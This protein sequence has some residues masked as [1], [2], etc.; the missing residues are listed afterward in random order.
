MT[1]Q[2]EA[3]SSTFH[4]QPV[5]GLPQSLIECSAGNV[6]ILT[7]MSA[8]GLNRAEK[9]RLVAFFLNTRSIDLPSEVSE[10]DGKILA[11]FADPNQRF[12]NFW[13][14]VSQLTD[15]KIQKKKKSVVLAPDFAIL[16][17]F[18][19]NF[20]EHLPGH[21]D[22][23]DCIPNAV[24][25]A[26]QIRK[27]LKCEI[28]NPPIGLLSIWATISGELSRW[29]EHDEVRR[30]DLAEAVFAVSS[31]AG[32][33]YLMMKAIEKCQGLSEYFEPMGLQ[34]SQPNSPPQ[35]SAKE[36]GTA[37]TLIEPVVET[38]QAETWKIKWE[39]LTLQISE[40]ALDLR[41]SPRRDGID[42]LASALEELR[43][44]AP[45]VEMGVEIVNQK[46]QQLMLFAKRAL[47]DHT[48]FE[49]F[50]MDALTTIEKTWTSY[51]GQD[52]SEEVT[53]SQI[54]IVEKAL[55]ETAIALHQCHEKFTRMR[56]LEEAIQSSSEEIRLAPTPSAKK[57]LLQERN[58]KNNEL[59]EARS[60][61][62]LA[63]EELMISLCPERNNLCLDAQTQTS[64]VESATGSFD[65]NEV[66]ISAKTADK[67]PNDVP[68]DKDPEQVVFDTAE[69]TSSLAG[70]LI[71]PIADISAAVVTDIPTDQITTTKLS[72]DAEKPGAPSVPVSDYSEQ[73]GV[74]CQPIWTAL[75]TNRPG[76]AYW[77]AIGIQDSSEPVPVIPPSLL[78]SVALA[79]HLVLPDS[80][81]AQ[82]LEA[83]YTEFESSWFSSAG[84]TPG[85]WTQAL[86]LLLLSA[87]L[88]PILLCPNSGASAVA[89][90]LHLNNSSLH[91]IRQSCEH[92]SERAQ[93]FRI[94]ASSF[95]TPRDR[96][97]WL[98]QVDV[99][100]TEATAWLER[101]PSMKMLYQA[102]SQVW[103]IWLKP[104]GLIKRLVLAVANGDSSSLKTV[105]EAI[106]A[107]S[108]SNNLDRLIRETD[109]RAIG[110]RGEEI[111]TR[112]L[113]QL[114]TKVSEALSLARRWVA[115]ED[116]RPKSSDVLHQLIDELSSSVLP[117][118]ESA[119]K[120]LQPVYSE[121]SFGLVATANQAVAKSL[122]SIRELLDP[123]VELDMVEAKPDVVLGRDLA[124]VPELD[125]DSQWNP[126]SSPADI[127]Q[128]LQSAIT[129]N[130]DKE[131]AFRCR[132]EA[133]DLLNAERIL[134][135]ID[136]VDEQDRVE[137][138]RLVLQEE[139]RSH[140]EMLKRQLDQAR[141]EIETGLAH[142]LIAEAERAVHEGALVEIAAQLDVIR[143]F[144]PYLL[145]LQGL[146]DAM[147]AK[148]T[149]KIQEANSR[150]ERAKGLSLS[151]SAMEDI[152]AVINAGDMLTANEYL[153]RLENGE[154]IHAA[155][156]EDGDI[157]SAYFPTVSEATD[158]ALDTA[159]SID[160]LNAIEKGLQFGPLD[161]SLLSESRRVGSSGSVSAWYLIKQTH[162]AAR[163]R[164][165]VVLS[166]LGF[167]VADLIV[168]HQVGGRQ[169]YA[170]K[171]ETIEDRSVC[172]I[173]Y[174]GS[175]AKGSYRVICVWQRPAEEDVVKLIGDTSMSSATILLY[176]G[177]LN[178]R[179]RSES[180][181]LARAQ[182]RSFLLVDETLL[183]FLASRSSAPA[184][185]LFAATLPFSHSQPYEPTS[186][187]VPT[188]MFFGRLQEL[189]AVQDQSG[190]CFIYGGRQL[191]KTALLR[192]A[193][194]DFHSPAKDRFAR[195]ID[196]RAEGIG[197]HR[198]SSEIWIILWKVLRQMG[199]LPSDVLEPSPNIKGRVDRFLEVMKTAIESAP[200]RRFLLLLDEADS[201]FESDGRKDF[202]ET[203][204]LKE[205]MFS[206]HW[207][208]KVVFAG[209]HNVLR[210]TEQANHPLAHLGEPIKVGPLLAAEEWRDAEDLIRGPFAAAGF[211]FSGR[212][213]IT[214]VLAQTNYYPS[215][216]QLY[217]H[218][219]LRHML[220]A[221]RA[222]VRMPGPR[223][224]IRETDVDAV[225]RRPS[226]REEI[227]SKFQ[228]T[229]Q[230]D[231]RYEVIAYSLAYEALSG[232]ASVA[233]GIA[234]W[235]IS[236]KAR[237][238][239]P[240]GFEVTSDVAFRVLLEEM[241]A[242]GVL[243]R[244]E[245]GNYA[246][247][248]PN[249]LLLLG[250][251][252]DVADVLVRERELPVE[253]E[254]DSFRARKPGEDLSNP[255]RHPL[256]FRQR[257][258]LV[259]PGSGVSIVCGSAALGLDQLIEFLRAD[260][261]CD[262]VEVLD[263]SECRKGFQQYYEKISGNRQPGSTLLII[264]PQSGWEVEWVALCQRQTARL[265]SKDR[266]LHV[267][268]VADPAQSWKVSR[269]PPLRDALVRLELQQW[270]DGFA[271][272]WLIDLGLA[273]ERPDRVLV[274]AAIGY[275]PMLLQ[276]LAQ[277]K[278][279]SLKTKLDSLNDKLASFE[280]L[281]ARKSDFG[282]DVVEPI[283]LLVEI[284]K[285]GSAET[286][287]DL[288]VLLSRDALFVNDVLSW[289][290]LLR[291]ASC[292]SER[293]WHV[294]DFAGRVLRRLF[295]EQA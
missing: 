22:T 198:E 224:E 109:R 288:C 263:F 253:F 103:Q 94:D 85:P 106:S 49:L 294:D 153:Q 77:M 251:S 166:A 264:S 27:R 114:S 91:N 12:W 230:L 266:T 219:L 289:A 1:P 71:D 280:Y 204:R 247:R 51:I 82:R 30:Q 63:E 23:L 38:E 97:E 190:R 217:C 95:I 178:N 173:P 158:L 260:R 184:V 147:A 221:V 273:S 13:R 93:G 231:T 156:A 79:N 172:A 142:G 259:I 135:E 282:M 154:P 290:S 110:R 168:Q 129:A 54:K 35:L 208:F 10:S 258:G 57:I 102:A 140:R 118:I 67:N 148:R 31:A 130:M 181:R 283:E 292:D 255:I 161:F 15:A 40:I 5:W 191:G 45:S 43:S 144:K 29:H 24:E 262:F 197:I 28:S 9:K 65:S 160:V 92:F 47:D 257:R 174:F 4:N 223:Y 272:Q 177:R 212:N 59:S 6:R 285:L 108:T 243:R 121:D 233:E 185:A 125:L 99:L 279:A 192:K 206:S 146:F 17:S 187:V 139:I 104:D 107:V 112:A 237:G 41:N 194:R 89:A 122:I 175:R 34:I 83:L 226:L 274:Q 151:D 234:V 291:L 8:Y 210:T 248:N 62:F 69:S 90:F 250:N 180:S 84:N 199:V 236:E 284:A 157:F 21:D 200:N 189:Q 162:K 52:A 202:I 205:L 26:A 186:G 117:L 20:G 150:F 170:L 169:E 188:E 141:A 155:I 60:T 72:F 196:L 50:D 46:L 131:S 16:R 179:K 86:N 61:A 80:D 163:E 76:L 176:F 19:S 14:T 25:L 293:K 68:A 132:V 245:S 145:K 137:S 138:L 48:S 134:D 124:S 238:W 277:S 128:L 295:A 11:I 127:E 70:T 275:W 214:R 286:S 32:G 256:T 105:K 66:E 167:P 44:V 218:H 268:F 33:N 182:Q 123:N 75:R 246:L 115:L 96:A 159:Q 195:W 152:R 87:V 265:S 201:F 18:Q 203:R 3:E 213:L 254:P 136:L 126:V 193:E 116:Q 271:R 211:Y 164:L 240:H 261:D 235:N 267:I 228:L 165:K 74:R 249:V 37:E 53:K 78:A 171:T 7:M 2:G 98:H 225:Y 81:I 281:S 252:E 101:A 215:L 36:E 232:E 120:E 113:T 111:H 55:E 216:I 276:E 239:W 64:K 207:R 73:A 133:H 42:T 88:R 244:I 149:R 241:V 270:K 39:R 119:L 222:E 209:L 56:L 227:R 100:G 143:N 183:L 269:T 229:L 58:R 287:D 220:E 278:G 242:L